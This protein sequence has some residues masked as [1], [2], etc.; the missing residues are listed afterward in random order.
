VDL[1]KVVVIGLWGFRGANDGGIAGLCNRI[2]QTLVPAGVPEANIFAMSWNRGRNDDWGSSPDTEDHCNEIKK[3]CARP[4]YL[5]IIGHS[6]GGWAACKLANR[7]ATVPWGELND[8]R[9]D[10]T[11][12]IDPIYRTPNVTIELE[13]RMPIQAKRF[14]NW[15]QT[16][17]MNEPQHC[18]KIGDNLIC[19]PKHPH[20]TNVRM[21]VVRDWDGETEFV[22]CFGLERDKLT[23][24]TWIDSHKFIWRQIH[25]VIATD[26]LGRI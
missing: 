10:Y 5:A 4:E 22:N 26:V 6:L 19:G 8:F 25:D 2:S 1:S 24:H 3:R 12:L 17:G 18:T 11:A 15:Y 21:D 9:P 13:A 23:W 14:D 16:N 20:A 7:M